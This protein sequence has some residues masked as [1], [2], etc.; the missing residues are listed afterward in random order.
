MRMHV[1]R[2]GSVP[3]LFFPLLAALSLPFTASAQLSFQVQPPATAGNYPGLRVQAGVSANLAGSTPYA[4][5]WQKDGV[6][7]AN[8]PHLQGAVTVGDGR[9]GIG[10]STT[11]VNALLII[12]DVQPTDIGDYRAILYAGGLSITSSVCHIAPINFT[13]RAPVIRSAASDAAVPEGLSLI[14]I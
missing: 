1:L 5:Q 2:P 13:S 7:L 10:G 3:R 9:A 11:F 4:V 12:P 6:N 14:H 8:S